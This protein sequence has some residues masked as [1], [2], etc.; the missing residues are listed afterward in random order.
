MLPLTDRMYGPDGALYLA[1]G[2]LAAMLL[3]VLLVAV[4]ARVTTGPPSGWQ[5]W[6]EGW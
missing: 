5:T 2:L 3:A 4:A 6:L 1:A